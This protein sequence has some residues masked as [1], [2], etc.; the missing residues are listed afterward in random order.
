[1]NLNQ[2]PGLRACAQA[3]IWPAFLMA[4]V[5]EMLVFAAVDPAE[6][7]WW[8]RGP[9]LDWPPGAI[10]SVTFL[11]FWAL[12]SISGALTALLLRSPEDLNRAAAPPS[13]L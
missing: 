11:I 7:H 5:L 12:V 1:M 8:F 9:R 10:Y 2:R 4:G 6:M 13:R 3:A